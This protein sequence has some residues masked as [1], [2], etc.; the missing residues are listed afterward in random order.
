MLV[1]DELDKAGERQ[2]SVQHVH[3]VLN[4]KY[5]VFLAPKQIVNIANATRGK[6]KVYKDGH[7]GLL[8]TGR[9][10]LAALL[11]KPKKVQP[12]EC[13]LN[14]AVVKRLGDN[15][16]EEIRELAVAQ[17]YG[18]GLSA[19]FLTR[20]LIEKSLSIVLGK[21]GFENEIYDAQRR[22]KNLSN[23][24]DVAE[25]ESFKGHPILARRTAEQL[26]EIKFLQDTAVHNPFTIGNIEHVRRKLPVIEIALDELSQKR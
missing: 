9:Q 7:L 1:L 6:I 8:H 18:C 10:Q 25:K 17:I 13:G 19:A 22:L 26:R 16:E 20:K 21:A 14:P 11:G 24:L 15:F 12:H 3:E 2:P 5:G 4:E 23:L